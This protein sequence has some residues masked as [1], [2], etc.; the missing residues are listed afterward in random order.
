MNIC[1]MV[2]AASIPGGNEISWTTMKALYISGVSYDAAHAASATIFN[3][4]FGDSIIRK[5]ERV[6]LK[7][8][9]YR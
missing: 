6:K 7:Y 2:T 5:L 1:A 9:I 3:L 4:I 8:G